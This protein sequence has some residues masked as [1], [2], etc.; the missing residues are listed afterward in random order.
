MAHTEIRPRG[1]IGRLHATSHRSEKKSK[2]EMS[3]FKMIMG[4]HIAKL[5][6]ITEDVSRFVLWDGKDKI[7]RQ[8]GSHLLPTIHYHTSW[9]KK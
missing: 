8:Y 5:W 7:Y 2:L 9:L 1:S 3:R 4:A 6:V